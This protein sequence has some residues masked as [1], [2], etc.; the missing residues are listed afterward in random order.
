MK[1]AILGAGNVGGTLGRSLSRAG[2]EVLYAVRD[3]EDAKHDAL[4][5]ARAQ[6]KG[7]QE[8]VAEADAVL[9]ATPWAVTQGALEGAGDLGGKPLLDV[10]NPIGAGFALTHGWKDSGGEQV[11]RWAPTAKVVK[12]FNTTGVENMA[13]ADYGGGVRPVMFLCGDDAGAC[14]LATTLAADL[15]FEPV[16]IGPLAKARILEP[17]VLLWITASQK[18]GS[19]DIAFA[20]LR[21]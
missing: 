17:M 15:G 4:K 1:I 21:R 13:S 16:A 7:V 20:L 10:T 6:V 9:L 18:V 8:A 2:H 19:R 5:G 14:A 3:P 12:V 11:A